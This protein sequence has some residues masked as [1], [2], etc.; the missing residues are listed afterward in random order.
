MCAVCLPTY[1]QM[2]SSGKHGGR[3]IGGLEGALSYQVMVAQ[4]HFCLH[5]RGD[6]PTSRRFYDAI[7]A[8]CLPIVV[9]D[10]VPSRG[11]SRTL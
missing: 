2:L 4:S 9:S 3:R 6:T 7:A 11:G 10:E 1:L 5:L 8:G